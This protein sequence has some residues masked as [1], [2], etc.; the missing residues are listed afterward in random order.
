[1]ADLK[2]SALS[3][4]TT[5]LAGTE[6]LPIV[7]SNSTKK[8]S[9]ANL[10]AGRNVAVNKLQPT[11]NIEMALGKGIYFLEN[12]ATPGVSS[13]LLND[14]ETGTWT[15]I[16]QKSGGSLSATFTSSGVYTK[17]GR[18]VTL[19]GRINITAIASQT[20]SYVIVSGL[21]FVSV[22]PFNNYEIGGIVTYNSACNGSVVT[23][24]NLTGS[25]LYAGIDKSSNF[26]PDIVDWSIGLL[27]FT[28]TY[29]TT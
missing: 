7:Q 21:P 25:E 27:S 26:P 28:I 14:Y 6:I 24:M 11:D 5:P 15:P 2:I 23:K 17:I 1:M 8:V 12:P 29:Y 22:F 4:S 13:K 20:G 3:N 19:H 18:L 10:T 16:P 9:V